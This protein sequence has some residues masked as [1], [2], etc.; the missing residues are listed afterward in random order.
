MGIPSFFSYIIKNYPTIIKRMN[1][2]TLAINNLYLDS[3]SIIYDSM[4]TIK[5]DKDQFET[6]LIQSICKKIDEYISII[7]PTKTIIIAFDGVAP[8]A[9]LEQQRNRRYKSYFTK[10]IVNSISNE[11]QNQWD[12]TAITPGTNFMNK[13]GQH[14]SSYYNTNKG[15]Y[16]AENIIVSTSNDIGEGEHKIFQFIRDHP[17]KHKKETSVIYGL[18]AD[19]IM[20]CLNHLH[21]SSKIY[22]YRETPEFIKSIDARLIPNEHYILDIPLL[23]MGI[24]HEMGSTN[25]NDVFLMFDYIFLCFFL[26]NDF[27]PHFPSMNI[28]TKGINILIN[29]YKATMK[30]NDHFTNGKEIVWKNVRKFIEYLA[31]NEWYNLTQEYKI[32]ERW[33]KR[34][35]SYSN[36]ENKMKRFLHIPIKNRELEKYIDPHQ[37]GWENRYYKTLF[38]I[39]ITDDYRRKICINYLEGLEWTFKYYTNECADWRW[40]YHYDYPPLLKDLLK[41]VPYWETNMIEKNNHVAVTPHVQLSYVL[42]KTSLHLLPE[43]IQQTLLEEMGDIYKMDCEFMWAFCKYFWECHPKLPHICLDELEKC[44]HSIKI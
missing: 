7:K 39:D 23:S 15:R 13:L 33:E 5:Y 26:G 11:E 29:A 43:E 41:Y 22:L 12:Q 37:Q 25:K 34:H 19:L 44:V 42:P 20:L 36:E 18:D 30:K 4:R 10:Q 6:M 28:R 3:N 40:F 2:H 17:K 8:V 1:N 31:D 24:I 14:I 32:R 38:G 27:M 9:K 16:E 35:F 21:I